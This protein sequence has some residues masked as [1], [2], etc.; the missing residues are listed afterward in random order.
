M[1]I[2][3]LS[4]RSTRPTAR[5]LAEALGGRLAGTQLVRPLRADK[6]VCWGP[7]DTLRPIQARLILSNGN[8]DKLSQYQ[9]LA[10]IVPEFTTNREKAREWLAEGKEVFARTLLRAN[11]GKGIIR[12]TGDENAPVYTL[13]IPKKHEYRIHVFNGEIID[14]QMKKGRAGAEKNHQIRNLANGFIYA[15]DGINIPQ[16]AR[17]LAL[18]AV[19]E[20]NYTWGAVDLIHNERQKKIYVLE[21]NSA[22]GLTGT[23]LRKYADAIRQV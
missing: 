5:A 9:T 8:L 16:E 23:T 1:S 11:S 18:R 20:L 12:F 3:I 10:E 4:P 13:Y 14:E 7:V 21:V 22:P 19:R 2:K 6:V 15:R 17:E